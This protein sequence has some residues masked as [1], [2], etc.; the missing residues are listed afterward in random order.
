MASEA[1]ATNGDGANGLSAE[2]LEKK[3]IKDEKAKEKAKEKDAKKAKAAAKAA[4]AAAKAAEPAAGPS[5][6]AEQKAKK[7]AAAASAPG[8]EG[9]DDSDTVT[10]VTPAG[11]KKRLAPVM[12]KAYNPAAVEAS[13]YEWWEK[14]GFFTADPTSTKPPFVI[15]VPPPNVTGA[16]HIGHALT[17]SVEDTLCRWRRM[18][19]YNVCWVPGV[20]HA[21][22]ATQVVV[23]KKVM[24]ERGLNRHDL[25][26][27]Q[28]V[29]EV[30]KWKTT[31]GNRIMSQQRKLG[32]SLDWSRECFTMDEKLSK[33]V[34]EAFVQLHDQGLIYRDNRLVN[35]DC[36]LKT[37]ISDIEVDYKELTG[38]TLLRVP[39]YDEPVE[40]GAIT[41]FAYPLQ[42]GEGNDGAPIGP[43]TG[44]G[45]EEI[46]VA[47]TRPETMLGDT[48]VAVHPLDERY[49]HLHGKFAVH[50]FNGRVIPI[51]CDAELVK[52]EFGTG[53]VKITP[54]HDPND[55]ATGKRHNL[56]FINVLTDDGR[57]NSAGGQ[58]F[59]GMKR[60]ECRKKLVKR[61][62][63]MGLYRGVAPNPMSL[64]FCSRSNDVIEPM[65][66]PQWYV[67]CGEMAAEAVRAVDDGSLAIIP[68][69]HTATWK[70]WLNDIRDW[71]IS[72]QLWWGHRIPAWYAT[73]EGDA[74]TE[75]GSYN[76]HWIVARSAKEA[77]AIVRQ[78][79]GADKKFTMEQDP[80]VLDT[81]FSSGLFPFSVF[82]WPDN[83]KDM[84]AFYP[85]S[86]LETGHDI[87]FFWV[88]RMVMLGMRLTGKLPFREIFLH[89]M[90]RDA[91]GRKMSK[92]LG[93]VIDP[94]EVINGVSLADL[95]KKLEEGNLD[96]REV[97]KAKA[98]Q[99]EDFPEGIK[100]CGCDALRFALVAYTAQSISVNLD[101]L[102][103]VGYRQ[104]C[105]KLWN[106]TRF[107][108]MNLGSSFSPEGLP[109]V[110]SLPFASRWILSTFSSAVNRT[111]RALEAYDLAEATTAVY[112]WWQYQ[113]CDVFIEVIKPVMAGSDDDPEAAKAKKAT[114]EALWVCLD[115]GLRLLHPLMPFVTEELWQRLPKAEGAPESIVIAPYPTRVQEWEDVEGVEAHMA[116]IEVAV[117]AVR[118][119]R[120]D[121]NL[122]K[123]RAELFLQCRSGASAAVMRRGAQEIATLAM[124]SKVQVLVE[125]EA[126]PLGCAVK[127][128]DDT[129]AAHLLLR[130]IV[131]PEAEIVKLE[132]KREE[133]KR[134]EEALLKKTSAVGYS[135]KVPA[136]V[137]VENNAKAAKFAAELSSIEEAL[138]NFEKLRSAGGAPV[139]QEKEGHDETPEER[140]ARRLLSLPTP[141]LGKGL[142]ATTAS[143]HAIEISTRE[144]A[145]GGKSWEERGKGGRGRGVGGAWVI[146]DGESLYGPSH[147]CWSCGLSH[148]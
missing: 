103:V 121:Y 114:R 146:K 107:A 75:M 86:V 84:E 142:P 8:G 132:K 83:T 88:A 32:A 124:L 48:A 5:K 143:A 10:P 3:R 112:A 13:W 139:E 29:E 24:R 65:I 104:W 148:S 68:N 46:V 127:I 38:Q 34:M 134:F 61:L 100:E 138:R 125:G 31:F 6:K 47:T 102:R 53:A 98:G 66:K 14:S 135:E 116:Q 81:W 15:V 101:I 91:H 89:G 123:Q 7:A 22:I 70:R 67:R 59:E 62:E 78:R 87:L 137:Q 49:K 131:D 128:V 85:T 129:V 4:A 41:S 60:F 37:A 63:E 72:R 141:P 16:L 18:S 82:G 73:L 51:I 145:G 39:G 35:W 133:T 30:W 144:E 105:N 126:P 55:F 2:E 96:K 80:D 44:S 28:F 95:H 52:M 69:L 119:L 93:N 118:A 64:G 54:A 136:A 147:S 20:D 21:G 120:M 77:E 109:P 113:L 90:V 27:D 79:F 40:F 33:A 117:R 74:L 108:L 122:Q 25:G 97:E 140:E 42:K 130:G 12:A 26:R 56:E 1:P 115:G 11:E 19:G 23:E 110:S 36:I 106:A 43:G 58:E 45:R 9:E 17:G 99:A 57:I 92:S 50:P 94:L 71:C 111:V 76:D